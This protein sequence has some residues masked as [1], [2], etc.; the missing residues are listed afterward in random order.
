[1]DINPS[2]R[3]LGACNEDTNLA[4]VLYAIKIPSRNGFP[5]GATEFCNMHAA[6]ADLSA[7]MKRRLE[8][9]TATHDFNKFWEMMRQRGSARPPLTPAQRA[10]RPPVSHPVVMT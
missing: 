10:A 7:E 4:N 3:T 6:Y 2:G 5:L 1:M 9:L 8:G